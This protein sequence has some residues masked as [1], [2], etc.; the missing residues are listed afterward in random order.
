MLYEL[1]TGTT[2]LDLAKTGPSLFDVI[3]S[4]R[5]KEPPRPSIHLTELGDQLAT[6]AA[7]RKTEPAKLLKLLRGELD[8][9]VLKALEIC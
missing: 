7:Q 2:P 6:I 8:W 3:K 9:I 5:E 1:L 4:I